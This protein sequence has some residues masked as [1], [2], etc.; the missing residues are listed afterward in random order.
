MLL[1]ILHCPGQPSTA[2]VYLG[3]NVSN[4]RL[5][6]LVIEQAWV[7]LLVGNNRTILVTV[8]LDLGAGYL[9]KASGSNICPA[10][11]G[12]WEVWVPMRRKAT[13]LWEAEFGVHP[14]CWAQTDPGLAACPFTSEWV[15]GVISQSCATERTHHFALYP[16]SLRR[17]FSRPFSRFVNNYNNVKKK[18]Q[19][20]L[21]KLFDLQTNH[22]QRGNHPLPSHRS[23]SPH[24]QRTTGRERKSHAEVSPLAPWLNLNE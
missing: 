1:N 8:S 17:I 21:Y 20:F 7:T 13:V 4:V 12:P 22:I 16:L 24:T 11:G 19:N 15:P 14:T 10:P 2:K 23:L 6:N 5:R 18:K 9:Q 3:Q